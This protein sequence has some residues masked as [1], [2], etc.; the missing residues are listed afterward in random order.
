MDYRALAEL[1]MFSLMGL[2]ILTVSVGFS[3]RFFLTPVL[4]DILKRGDNG[5]PEQAL[6]SARMA[7]I[8]DRLAAIEDSVDRIAAASEF[9]RQLEAPE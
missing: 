5:P 1:A 6:L 7:A 4:R 2:S 8:E 3:I 9:D